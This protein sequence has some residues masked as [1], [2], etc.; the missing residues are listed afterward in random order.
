MSMQLL[1]LESQS[2]L[3][4]GGSSPLVVVLGALLTALLLAGYVW[5]IYD[6][7]RLFG[8]AWAVI[9]AIVGFFALPFIWLVLALY[10]ITRCQ[11][12]ANPPGDRNWQRDL[13]RMAREQ[14]EL[15]AQGK[16]GPGS[17]A[18]MRRDAE[19]EALAEKGDLAGAIRLAKERAAK[20]LDERDYDTARVYENYLEDFR[21]GIKR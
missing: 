9:L 10:Y 1:L 16:H 8:P 4:G 7:A 5:M 18:Y 6:S 17:P 15:N 13:N 21:R 3:S 14:E 19:V 11:R 20:A 12:L 2:G